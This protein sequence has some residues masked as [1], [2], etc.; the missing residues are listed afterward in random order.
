MK[1]P[2]SKAHNRLSQ[3]LKEVQEQPITITRHGQPI[4][5]I[6][7]HEEYQRLSKAKAYLQIIRL[8]QKLDCRGVN[9][10]EL[11]RGSRDELEA[12]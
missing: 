12:R 9:A 10:E 7:S 1:I 8:S 2:V 11:A 5:V 3:L 4:G 6:I